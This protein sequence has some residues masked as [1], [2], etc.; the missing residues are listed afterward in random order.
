MTS[1]QSLIVI[2]G[3]IFQIL[4]VLR[5]CIACDIIVTDKIGRS[6]DIQGRRLGV[7]HIKNTRRTVDGHLAVALHFIDTLCLQFAV[8]TFMSH[9]LNGGN[10]AVQS[11]LVGGI[12]GAGVLNHEVHFLI[13]LQTHDYHTISHRS[14]GG[15]RTIIVRAVAI[16]HFEGHFRKGCLQVQ[17]TTEVCHIVGRKTHVGHF[18]TA[19]SEIFHAMRTFDKLVVDKSLSL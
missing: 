17:F 16:F 15:S 7:S 8:N 9:T 5:H 1:Q 14:K 10:N 4:L 13:R 6:R 3:G 12:E 2:L 18:Q 19:Q 11:L